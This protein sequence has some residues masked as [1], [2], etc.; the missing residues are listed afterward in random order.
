MKDKLDYLGNGLAV[1]FTAIQSDEVF[2]IIS[3]ILTCLSVALTIAYRV[4][5]WYKKAKKDGKIDR[6]EIKDLADIMEEE[7]DKIDHIKKEN[8]K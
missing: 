2:R 1:I 8:E 7:K 5:E 4:R 6:E 3:L